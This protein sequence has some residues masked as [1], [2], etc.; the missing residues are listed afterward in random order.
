MRRYEDGKF[1]GYIIRVVEWRGATYSIGE[2]FLY[3]EPSPDD[4][5]LVL[6]RYYQ[7]TAPLGAQVVCCSRG[8]VIEPED[9]VSMSQ[10]LERALS[11]T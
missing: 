11:G 2:K 3:R 8:E 5:V 10:N 6:D 7:A 1:R 9:A 4:V